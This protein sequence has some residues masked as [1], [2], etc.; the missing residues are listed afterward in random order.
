MKFSLAT[1]SVHEES[2]HCL[3]LPVT[4]GKQL[5]TV[6]QNVDKAS[7][8]AITAAIKAGDIST[9]RGHSLLMRSLKGITAERVLLVGCGK[10]G[11]LEPGHFISVLQKSGKALKALGCGSAACY[12]TELPVV[13]R[14]LQW[15]LAL[16]VQTL[17]Q[18]TYQFTEY[19]SG[20]KKP[21]KLKRIGLSAASETETPA[22]VLKA[23]LETHTAIAA[24]VKL[25][26]DLGNRPGNDCTPTFLASEA[27][28]LATELPLK[29]TVLDEQ[30][31]SKLKMDSLLSVGRGSRQES[32]LIIVEYKGGTAAAKPVV[33]V[34]KGVTFDSGGIS[35]KPAASMEE[36]KY[37]MCGAASVLGTLQAAAAA[38][39][40]INLV[41]IVPAVENMPDGLANKPGDI[42]TSMSG[43]TIEIIN[44]DAEGR[45][46][47]ADA[48][49]YAERYKP[50]VVI[51]IATLTG[52]CIIA[53]G[54]HLSA[55]LGNSDELIDDLIGA[56]IDSHDR[57]WQLPLMEEY[58]Q[59]IKSNIADISNVGGRAAGTVT[60]ACF[61]SRFTEK[62]Q[63]AHIDIAGTAWQSG[64]HKDA[65]GRPVPLLMQYLLN[66]C[67]S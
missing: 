62:V 39:L 28:R 2:A 17:E 48:L 24:G 42:V 12:L 11:E 63:W 14:D 16:A 61:L 21:P 56:G 36:M 58:Q 27:Q 35:L 66:R 67:Q 20:K 34:G 10:A 45:L 37:D 23:V 57:A 59:Q 5:P 33:L 31:M 29:T 26:R 41:G 40:P 32:K 6:T 38:N 4:A 50:D 18:A 46:I 53:L 22:K 52:A 65:T 43:K 30:A 13:G 47:L 15:K 51:D 44:T 1:K 49:T 3:V 8:G 25:A 7:D 55:V 60:A 19:K 54:H 9:D 64:K